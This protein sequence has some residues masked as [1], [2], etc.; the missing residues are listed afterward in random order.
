MFRNISDKQGIRESFRIVG[1]VSG[2]HDKS[3][4]SLG[5]LPSI[6]GHYARIRPP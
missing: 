1:V 2:G 4:L 6:G 5:D 3:L